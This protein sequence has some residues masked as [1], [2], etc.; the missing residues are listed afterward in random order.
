VRTVPVV[1]DQPAADDIV[2]FAHG[3]EAHATQPGRDRPS[4]HECDE[5]LDGWTGNRAF[6]EYTPYLAHRDDM[7]LFCLQLSRARLACLRAARSSEQ[8]DRCAP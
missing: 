1:G 8:A 6:L 7:R 3:L 2:A 4:L 5:L